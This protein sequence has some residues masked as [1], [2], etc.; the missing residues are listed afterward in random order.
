MVQGNVAPGFRKDFQVFLFLQFPPETS[1]D[2]R[3]AR[4]WLS[5]VRPDVASAYEVA[6]FNRL[7]KHVRQRTG[8]DA[9]RTLRSTWLNVAFT[10]RGLKRL[11]PN[12]TIPTLSPTAS[13]TASFERG[14]VE[15]ESRKRWSDDVVN[16]ATWKVLDAFYD[17]DVNGPVQERGSRM[18][19]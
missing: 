11:A 2:Q 6:V 5:R 13:G 16:V 8:K 14:M 17:P 9:A 7:Y 19:S 10:A 1:N 18:S 3:R 12:I 4:R 15:S